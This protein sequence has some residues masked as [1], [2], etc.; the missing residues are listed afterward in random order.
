M[1]T[2]QMESIFSGTVCLCVFRALAG[3]DM[4]A[5]WNISVGPSGGEGDTGQNGIVAEP[6]PPSTP[7]T[8]LLGAL[9]GLLGAGVAA[10]F[11]AFHKK[12]MSL[13]RDYGLLHPD[14]TIQRALVGASCMLFIGVLAP[15]TM[16]WGESEFQVRRYL[17]LQ[18]RSSLQDTA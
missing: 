13:F 11:A 17:H 5:V 9:L 14:R 1:L 7:S 16:F 4:G 2:H 6:V 12:N 18:P 10:L 15:R 8:V 3:L